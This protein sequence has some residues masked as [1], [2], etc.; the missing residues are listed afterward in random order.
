VTLF[1]SVN[2]A[3]ASASR[4]LDVV[5]RSVSTRRAMRSVPQSVTTT[6]KLSAA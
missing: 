1:I 2:D 6:A 5:A 4:T 3:L